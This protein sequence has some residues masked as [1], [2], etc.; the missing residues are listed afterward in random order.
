MKTPYYCF[1]GLL[2]WLLVGCQGSPQPSATAADAFPLFPDYRDVT[3]PVGIAPLNFQ[4][5]DP[6]LA[7]AH[8]TVRGTTRSLTVRARRGL[9]AFPMRAWHQ[10][11]AD[12]AGHDLTVAVEGM[13]AWTIHVSSLPLADYG[14]VYRLIAPG[15]EV[16]SHIGLYQRDLHNFHEEAIVES[17]ALPGQCMGCHTACR[18]DAEQFMFHLRGQ[19]GAT[20]VQQ[21]GQREWLVTKTDSTMGNV[22]YTYWHPSGRYFVGSINPVRQSFWTGS[23]HLIEVFDLAS[24]VVVADGQTHEL[25]L[26]PQLMTDA[27]ETA[28]AFS[29]DGRTIFF[30]KAMS[31]TRLADVDSIRYN[32]CA[33]SFDEHTGLVGERIDTLLHAESEGYSVSWPRPSYDGRWL[34]YCRADYGCFPVNHRE[35]DLWL[36]DLADGSTRSLDEVNSDYAESF[37][38]W[39]SDS[40]WFV[41]TS[42]RVDGLHGHLYLASIDA[43]GHVTRPFLLPQRNPLQCYRTGSY[44]YNVPD[45]THAPI[46][47]SMRGVHREVFSDQRSHL[48]VHSSADEYRIHGTINSDAYEGVRIFLVP[49]HDQ[50]REVVD[51]VEIHDRQFTFRGTN[52][53]MAVVRLDSRYRYGTQEL[54]VATEPGDI[55]VQVDSISTGG[56]TPQNDSLEV[57]KGLTQEWQYGLSLLAREAKEAASRGDTVRVAAVRQRQAEATQR[58]KEATQRMATQL[59]EGILHDF[60][61]QRYPLEKTE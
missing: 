55:Y 60:L 21:Q 37:H 49:L 61:L 56:G 14:L 33:V 7:R 47:F 1:I 8:V 10:L 20:L 44:S 23:E 42:R 15:Y 18:T 35:A 11:L 2:L 52:H 48:T 30:G 36:L 31:S 16:Y 58:Y 50:S 41:F 24:D 38:N 53:W 46:T 25:H 51:S 39:S 32:L 34:M 12:E 13:D 19:H 4:V 54:L 3:I 5:L 26:A 9:V 40:H 59:G 45:F 17:T 57:W 43:D 28:P 27:R 6:S 29:A 22:A